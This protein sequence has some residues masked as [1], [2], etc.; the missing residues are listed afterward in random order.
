MKKTFMLFLAVAL[1]CTTGIARAGSALY[2]YQE[3]LF[4]S[5]LVNENGIA[6]DEGGNITIALWG[7]EAA[8]W[9]NQYLNDADPGTG[10][11]L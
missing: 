9:Y 2:D 3:Y 4:Y 10:S 11:T 5:N 1:I 6:E 7:L 8:Y